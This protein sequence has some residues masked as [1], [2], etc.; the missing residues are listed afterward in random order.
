ML[1]VS[2]LMNY[3]V[4]LVY[5][6][7][8]IGKIDFLKHMNITSMYGIRRT[9]EKRRRSHSD[10]ESFHCLLHRKDIDDE[11]SYFITTKL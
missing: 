8:E 4:R 3:C 7:E 5:R 1:D 10:K 9:T 6:E 11:I 2:V